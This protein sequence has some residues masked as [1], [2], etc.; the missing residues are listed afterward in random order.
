MLTLVYL[1]IST[2]ADASA[3]LR[4]STVQNVLSNLTKVLCTNGLLCI[5]I[6]KIQYLRIDILLS[7][8]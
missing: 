7:Q 8:E 5:I 2:N 3:M 4:V 6:C 1:P